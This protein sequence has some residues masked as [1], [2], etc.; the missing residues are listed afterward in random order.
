M[1]LPPSAVKGPPPTRRN[2]PPPASGQPDANPSAPPAENRWAITGGRQTGAQRV[3]IYGPG[4]I[5]KSSLAALA[6][7]PIVIDVE[8]STRGLDVQRIDGIQTWAELRACLQ[9]AT[10][11]GFRTIVI[12]S[13]TK[14]EEMAAT[15]TVETVPNEKG[16]RVKS[17]EGYG[18]GK[19]LRH[20]HETYLLLL[21]DLD[22]HVR[23]GRNVVLIAHACT[24]PVPNPTGDDWL[25]Y[26]PRLMGGTKKGECSNRERTF[27]WCDH[28]LYVGYDVVSTDGKGKGSGTRTIYTSEDAAH[29]AK[30]RG[31]DGTLDPMAFEHN[32]D[33]AVWPLI[34]GGVA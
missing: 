10:L 25:Q 22:R 8:G 12:D 29:K 18:F 26:Q 1:T 32:K 28:A 21:M 9:S 33:G 3:L 4:G 17:L 24:T 27:E 31:I 13:V 34:L 11:D 2:A 14:A 20:H 7:N 6:P 19:G 5:G 30:V 15:H 16:Q 23:A